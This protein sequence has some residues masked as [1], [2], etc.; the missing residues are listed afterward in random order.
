[1]KNDIEQGLSDSSRTQ[2]HKYWSEYKT[3]FN[4]RFHGH[5]KISTSE[6]VQLFVAYLS[7]HRKLSVSTIRCYISGIAFYSKLHYNRDPTKSFGMTM[8]LKAYGKK[9]IEFHKASH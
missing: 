7:N 8:L 6:Q 1:M 5:I 3:F 2:Y 9:T 4:S